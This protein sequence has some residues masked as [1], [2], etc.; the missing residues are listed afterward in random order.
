MADS[1]DD[2]EPSPA[3]LGDT[4]TVA[5]G[6]WTPL[7]DRGTEIYL[8]GDRPVDIAVQAAEQNDE[9]RQLHAE[10]ARLRAEMDAIGGLRLVEHEGYT[11]KVI[12]VALH[13]RLCRAR[14]ATPQEGTDSEVSH[15]AFCGF[16]YPRLKHSAPSSAAPAT[17][18][19]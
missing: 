2:L 11:L 13:D 17:A 15:C 3:Q 4:M 12:T 16:C 7:D 1:H 18:T 14:V 10:I 5:P 9:V 19:E 6:E 8:Y